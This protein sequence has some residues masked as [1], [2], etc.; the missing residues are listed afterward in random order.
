MDRERRTPALAAA[1]IAGLLALTFM[2]ELATPLG[3]ATWMLYTLAVGAALLQSDR[4]VPLVV[5]AAGTL[6]MVVGFFASPPG[7]DRF[8]SIANRSFGAVALWTVAVA[9]HYVLRT[10]D[11]VA[12]VSW[13]QRAR[14]A[15]SHAL[16]G[17][18]GTEEIGRNATAALAAALDADVG[19]LYRLD[20]DALVRSGGH[21]IDPQP[22]PERIAIGEGLA[23][24]AAADGA[25]RVLDEV[26]ADHLA[27]STALGRSPAG[28]LVV[29]PI[30]ADGRICGVVELASLSRTMHRDRAVALLEAVAEPVGSALRAAV[31][32]ERLLALLEETGHQREELQR[33]QEL[34]YATNEELEEQSRVLEES[35]ARLE[36]QQEALEQGNLRLE[37][38]TQMLERHKRE[39]LAVQQTLLDNAR[40]LESANRYKSEFVANMSHELRTPLNSALILSKLL[41]ENREGTLTATQVNYAKAIHASNN[42]L[43]TL[44]NDVLDLAKIEAGHLELDVT[45][46]EV[47]IL[48]ERLRAIF[49]PMARQKGLELHIDA[50]AAVPATFDTDSLRLSQVLKNL[51]ANAVKFTERGHVSLKVLALPGEKLAFEVRDT[52]V[53][54]ARDQLEVIFEAFRQAEGGPRHGGTGLGL[55]ISREL[56]RRLGGEILVDSEPGR[57][58]VF[59]LVVPLRAPAD[60]AAPGPDALPA[61]ASPAASTAARLASS[62]PPAVSAADLAVPVPADDRDRPRQRGRLVLCIEDDQPFAQVLMDLA[63]ERGF[64][65]LIAPTAAEALRLAARFRPDCILLDI[66]LPDQ[67]GLSVLERLKR[68]PAT[69]HVPV[70]VVSVHERAHTARKLGAIGFLHKPVEREQLVEVFQGIEQRLQRTVR[71]L[72]V[73]EGDAVRRAGLQAL[74]RADGLEIVT[75]GGIADALRELEGSTFDCMVTDLALSDGSAHGLLERIA[76]RDACAFPPVVVYTA[77]PIGRDDEERLRR[78]SRSIVVKG[79]RSP[80]RLLDEVTLFLH[81]VESRLPPDQQKLLQQV[82]QRDA[83]LD[84]RRI[85]LAEDDVRSIFALSSALEPLGVRLEIARNGREALEKLRS[86]PGID[87]VLM[88]I[89]MPEMDGLAAIRHIR[90][91]PQ[92]TSLPVIVLTAKAMGEDRDRCLAAGASDYVAKPID[93]DKLVSLCR[94]WMPR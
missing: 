86:V 47:P 19:V 72:L 70:H 83:V 64:D 16:L 84:G 71:R 8:M 40:N 37:E 74:L 34:L 18:Q 43:L 87:L 76:A 67:S 44:I 58:S 32:R 82:R 53:G 5:A 36:A 66:A 62:S 94:V 89:M 10:R 4:R 90:G 85:L 56:A 6:L 28:R 2:V 78:H 31:Y 92:W 59:T 11:E 41:A 88:D 61:V 7:I 50:D 39:L 27:I 48:F 26:P 12:E 9:I 29:A 49:A 3:Y 42:D 35:Q 33:Q 51:M 46:V 81:S 21:A 15:L 23:G 52:G 24:Q 69:R 20:G 68:D 54:I 38:R 22:L 63:H 1:V 17:D 77:G 55:S 80:E 57:G 25:I 60:G 79:A 30:R 14:A 75:V 93:V 73:V 13:L 45:T 91:Q 65:C